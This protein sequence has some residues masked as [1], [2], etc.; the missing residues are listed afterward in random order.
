[1]VSE[2]K[3]TEFLIIRRNSYLA[4]VFKLIRMI[5]I[6]DQR[7]PEPAKKKLE[8]YG[9]LV[10]LKTS[11]IV[12]DSISG[13]PD[14][15]ICSVNEKLVVAPNL[16]ESYQS[17]LKKNNVSFLQGESKVGDK[18]PETAAYNAVYDGKLLIHNFRYTDSVIT[19]IGEDTDL[20]HVSQGY[21]RCNLFPLRDNNFIT[22]DQGIQRVL[23]QIGFHVLYV[24]PLDILL[25]GVKHGFFGG[26]CGIHGNDVFIVGSLSKF[27]PGSEVRE[28]IETCGHRII[29]LYDGPLFDGGGLLFL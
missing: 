16:P 7:I 25:P 4:K 19:R 17:I 20:V 18:Y 10:L 13:H 3:N 21:T 5:I 26:C 6:A 27:G 1:L 28:F 22:S 14:I 23:E 8:V 29:E 15:F 11:G 12:Y 24:D 2:V 9:K